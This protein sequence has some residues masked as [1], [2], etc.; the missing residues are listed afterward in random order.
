MEPIKLV[1]F[2]LDSAVSLIGKGENPTKAL[3]KVAREMDLNPNYIQRTGEALNVALHYNHFKKAA[4]D[5]AKDFPVADI[6][7]VKTAIFGEV[8][9]TDKQKIAEWFPKVEEDIDYNKFLTNPKFKEAT[10]KLYNDKTED[11]SS[12]QITLQGQY[13]KAADYLSKLAKEID[14]IKTEKVGHDS[15]LEGLF[16]T[17]ITGFKKEASYR[18]SFHE[19]ETQA[20]AE[21]GD[22]AV[23]YLDLLYKTAGLTEARGTHDTSKITFNPCKELILFNSLLKTAEHIRQIEE[24]LKDAEHYVAEQ[25][26]LFKEAGYLLNEKFAS[27]DRQN[28]NDLADGFDFFLE[29]EAAPSKGSALFDNL[30]NKYR[31]TVFE[32]EGEKSPTFKNTP[33]DN[34]ERVTMLQH[35]LATDPILSKM[36]PSKVVRAYQTVLRLS[37]QISKEKEVV[38]AILRLITS[39]QSVDT[40][41]A[42][43]LIDTNINYL[44]QKEMLSGAKSK[45]THKDK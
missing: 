25:R 19:L 28:C 7:S 22:R 3:E 10:H 24:Q 11:Y 2:A 13:K 41:S 31:S 6:T 39:T 40:A 17:L 26:V 27:E 34:R 21:H 38:V 23:P 14:E 18:N 20:F 43:Q 5:K 36:D 42:N 44:K 4:E 1:K 35:I 15:Y 16:N 12:Y 29:K 33:V 30:F 37:P 9:K 8:E 45:D 32:G